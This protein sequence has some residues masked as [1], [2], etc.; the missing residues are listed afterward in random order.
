[1]LMTFGALTGVIGLVAQGQQ[2][3]FMVGSGG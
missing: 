2:A 1:M 3:V